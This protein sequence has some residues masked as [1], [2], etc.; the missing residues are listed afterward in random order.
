[1]VVF[2]DHIPNP[3]EGNCNLTYG[4]QDQKGIT[5]W[6]PKTTDIY[7]APKGGRSGPLYFT[8]TQPRCYQGPTQVCN[9]TYTIHTTSSSTSNDV[10]PIRFTVNGI[11]DENARVS[12]AGGKLFLCFLSILLVT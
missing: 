1:M 6:G 12:E 8:F 3:D 2:N 5:I 4:T 7:L 9:V 11:T 10:G